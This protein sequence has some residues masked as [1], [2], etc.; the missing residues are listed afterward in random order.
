MLG[1]T[2]SLSPRSAFMK[3]CSQC[4]QE[5]V[6]REWNDAALKAFFKKNDPHEYGNYR[7]ISLRSHVRHG[8]S[9]D[10]YEVIQQE[11]VRY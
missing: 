1:L 4:G 6:P 8:G 9:Q 5:V 10:D 2:Q 7:D 11:V 3:S